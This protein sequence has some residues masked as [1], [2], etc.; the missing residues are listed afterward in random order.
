MLLKDLRID[1]DQFI[2]RVRQTLQDLRV[3]VREKVLFDIP[4]DFKL[5]TT[6]TQNEKT[7]GH[8]A[9]GPPDESLNNVDSAAFLGALLKDGRLCH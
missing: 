4:T 8:S 3:H 7:Y 6:D 5:P 1:I 2:S 9:F